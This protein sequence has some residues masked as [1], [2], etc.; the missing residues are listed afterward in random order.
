METLYIHAFNVTYLES[1]IAGAPEHSERWLPVDL[2]L[3]KFFQ[4][5]LY[6]CIGVLSVLRQGLWFGD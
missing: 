2:R 4:M 1:S 6:S 3:T 5:K